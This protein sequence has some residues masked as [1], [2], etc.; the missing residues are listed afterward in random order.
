MGRMARVEF[1]NIVVGGDGPRALD[2]LIGGP[3][4]SGNCVA[5]ENV[6]D[7]DEAVLVVTGDFI[8]AR[9]SLGLNCLDFYLF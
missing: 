1:A 2:Q 5:V 9:H 6:P 3:A 4:Q 8:S 7:Q